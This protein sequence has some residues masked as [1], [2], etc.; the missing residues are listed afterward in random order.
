VEV[1]K[2]GAHARTITGYYAVPNSAS[3]TGR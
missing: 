3:E 2:P 1:D